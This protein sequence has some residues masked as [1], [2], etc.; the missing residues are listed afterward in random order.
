M[1]GKMMMIRRFGLLLGIVLLGPFALF[2]VPQLHPA[3][4]SRTLAGCGQG[5]PVASPDRQHS[6]YISCVGAD[7]GAREITLTFLDA[8]GRQIST[9]SARAKQS[10]TP[11]MPS[12]LDNSRVGVV[13]RTDP[14][15]R[16]YLVFNIQAGS[17]AAYPGYSFDWSPDRKILADVKLDVMFG[18]P[19]G[20]NS[21]LL[22][23]GQAIYPTR[24]DHAKE[25]YN[26]IHT[27]LSPPAWSPDSSKVA[28]VEKIFDWEYTDPFA[29][30]FDGE[31][32]NVRYYLVIASEQ[33]A[34]GYRL[35]PAA[36]E[37]LPA[38]QTNS[39]LVLG[40][41]ALDLESQPPTPIP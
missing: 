15:V 10:C 17:E 14:E 28:F 25:T 34:A 32:S 38:W 29:R 20:Q 2:A 6:A 24:C 5:S 9:L 18:T 7:Q 1:S 30:Y 22:L 31:A 35:D 26:H 41:Q 21:C 23:N 16:T 12:W 36:A 37:Q 40:S 13:C 19:V 27:F 4:A 3:E 33:G 8:A 39:R 11:G